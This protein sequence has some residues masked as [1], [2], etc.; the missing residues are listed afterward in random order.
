M[1]GGIRAAAGVPV[2]ALPLTTL[3][4]AGAILVAGPPG[5]GVAPAEAQVGTADTI[6]QRAEPPILRREGLAER[7]DGILAD[8]ALERAHVGMKVVVA[9]TGEVVYERAAE[10]RFIP[11][12]NVKLLTAAVALDVLGPDHRWTTRLHAG[13]PIRNGTLRGDLWVVGDGDPRLTR[14]DVDR[15]PGLLR[16]AGIRRI[17]GDLV[18]D[19]R[20]FTEP[21]WPDGWTW[22][23]LHTGWGTGST[24]LQLHPGRVRAHL[25]PGDSLGGPARLRLRD[26]G[27]GPDLD[28][29]VRTGAPG[30]E[31]RL[32]FLPPHDADRLRLRGW[33]PAGEDSVALNLAPGH[34]TLQLLRYV[35]SR[36]EDAGVAVEG[37][38]RRAAPEESRPAGEWTVSHRSE[39][40]EQ[41]L[42]ELLQQSDNQIAESLLRS[43]GREEGTAGSPDEGIAV[44]MERLA[45]WG[46][47]PGA[48]RLTD[49]SG[50]SRYD[51]A[52]PAALVRV[53]RAVWREPGFGPF[54]RALPA[55]AREGTLRARLLGTP[56]A[57]NLTGKTGS[58]SGVRALSGYVGD[59]AGQTLVFSLLL[60]GYDA[61]GDV[62]VA[63]EDLIV[64]QLSLLNRP[65]EPGWPEHRRP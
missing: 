42:A 21:P 25:H 64:E 14:D 13:G 7:L 33:I 49:G 19:D 30:S 51:R 26:V 31:V 38:L 29:Q 20:A 59:G 6:E 27:P 9:E 63:L 3:S 37:D 8:P 47:E 18:G 11:A 45:E 28:L 35:D 43:L 48:V 24:A 36:L 55:A 22:G 17:A 16:Q 40:L 50:L 32:R 23:D 46:V 4:L 58:L 44:V 15:W 2:V 52:S 10:R 61:P 54:A 39:P 5:A 41:V 65:V 1:R 34:P 56:A 62:A 12:S 57:G 60:N 53:L